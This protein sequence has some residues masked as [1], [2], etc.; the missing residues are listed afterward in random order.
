MQKHTV[1]VNEKQMLLSG[2]G[3][4]EK[5]KRLITSFLFVS[6]KINS[7]SL[8]EDYILGTAEHINSEFGPLAPSFNKMKNKAALFPAFVPLCAEYLFLS[9]HHQSSNLFHFQKI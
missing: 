1:S 7:F 9:L 6:K 3:C 5:A 2:F 8:G 4:N